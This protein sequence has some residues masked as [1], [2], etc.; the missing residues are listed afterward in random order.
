M[1][2]TIASI[3]RQAIKPHTKS[4]RYV[5][6]STATT[7]GSGDTLNTTL[8]WCIDFWMDMS[9]GKDVVGASGV[10]QLRT[11]QGVPFVIF[12]QK[13][14]NASMIYGAN[15]LFVARR[16]GTGMWKTTNTGWHHH[17]LTYDGSGIT[18][19]NAYLY[20]IDGIATTSTANATPSA[21]SN[22][23]TIG[24]LGATFPGIFYMAELRVYNGA[25]GVTAT[26][27]QDMAMSNIIPTG[28]TLIRNYLHDEGSGTVLTDNTGNQNGTIG[29][30]TWSNNIP[31]NSRTVASTARTQISISRAV[32][33]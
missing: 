16:G 9:D 8:P 6:S 22:L 1:P 12:Y 15:S 13:S 31:T 3:P 7:L 32:A 19:T 14:S 20:F 25:V 27:V 11:D 33:A 29:T 30:A 24:R 23:N 28:P 10:L 4:L 5:I 17:C 2:R 21:T 18:N 26:M